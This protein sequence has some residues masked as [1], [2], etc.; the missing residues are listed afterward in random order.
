MDELPVD[1]DQLNEDLSQL[2]QHLAIALLP[3]RMAAESVALAAQLQAMRTLRATMDRMRSL[4][5]IY[6]QQQDAAYPN[7]T[8]VPRQSFIC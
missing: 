5:W 3:N 7:L 8:G 4:L 6:L 2:E 1:L